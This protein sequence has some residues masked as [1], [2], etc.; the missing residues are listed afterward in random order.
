MGEKNYL[1]VYSELMSNFWKSQKMPEEVSDFMK[2]RW[3]KYNSGGSIEAHVGFLYRPLCLKILGEFPSL[4]FYSSIIIHLC[5]KSNHLDFAGSSSQLKWAS[6]QS[7]L[8]FVDVDEY[9]HW[10]AHRTLHSNWDLFY[11]R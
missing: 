7:P 8:R 9:R 1:F 3:K 5:A 2:Y 11:G 6:P 10:R 4:F